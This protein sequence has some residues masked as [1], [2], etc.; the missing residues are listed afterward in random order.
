[1][2]RVHVLRVGR[3]AG[4]AGVLFAA[5]IAV[6]G[7]QT[8]PGMAKPFL[9]PFKPPASERLVSSIAVFGTDD[10]ARMPA[11]G[12]T[13]ADQI[14]VLV[15]LER[16]TVCTAFCVGH[17]TVMTAGH[18][19]YPPG[20]REPARLKDIRFRRDLMT[21][22]NDARIAGASNGAG[23]QHVSAGTTRL[24]LRPP[25]DA[26]KDWAI[27]RL[28]RDVCPMGGLTLSRRTNEEIIELARERRVYQIAF[29]RD[30]Q[31]FSRAIARSCEVGRSFKD[32]GW[33]TISQDFQEPQSL[34]LH[35]CDTGG[36][37]SGSPLLIDGADGPEVVGLNVGTYLQ[38]NATAPL[39]G[40]AGRTVQAAATT[41]DIANTAIAAHTIANIAIEFN[42]AEILS[43]P[44]QVR[45]VAAWLNEQ[46]LYNGRRDGRYG[47]A[48]KSA[49]EAYEVRQGLAVTG[50]LTKSLW[51]RLDQQRNRSRPP[52][53]RDSAISAR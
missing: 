26:V 52:R 18:C 48:L 31:Y 25:I 7:F 37:S 51:Q 15:D 28:D 5:A 22:R 3:T 27:A 6:L 43:D 4:L 13:L 41:R 20:S 44:K 46:R 34:I 40:G 30:F 9:P 33:E 53:I 39:G 49:I 38:S 11:E 2:G 8:A 32:V 17:A 45:D 16:K 21:T 36:S 12:T 42:R 47:P 14:G 50:F 29:H 35:T 23:A 10:R 24:S 19:L 1:M